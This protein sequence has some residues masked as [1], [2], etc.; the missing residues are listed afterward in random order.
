MR[1]FF[2]QVHL[3]VEISW[4]FLQE[5]AKLWREA[6]S[7]E[8]WRAVF[9]CAGLADELVRAG[10][11]K[12][13]SLY[14]KPAQNIG[15]PE[16]GKS[17]QKRG[18]KGETPIPK[19]KKKKKSAETPEKGSADLQRVQPGEPVSFGQP[20]MLSTTVVGRKRK[21]LASDGD[22]QAAATAAAVDSALKEPADDVDASLKLR[23]PESDDEES[24]ETGGVGL[25]FK[26]LQRHFF[27]MPLIATK[28][29]PSMTSLQEGHS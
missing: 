2:H 14:G 28:C 29:F 16:K 13:L 6:I 7:D 27:Q 19:L 11:V 23:N 25:R 21:P 26:A 8:R 10:D 17:V 22:V 9:S 5:I 15:S 4:P 1:H 20:K 12:F 18:P 24:I 3:F